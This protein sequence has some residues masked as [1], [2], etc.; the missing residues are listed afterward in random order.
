MYPIQPSPV[1]LD[2]V[3][4]NMHMA[5]P[6]LL[7]PAVEDLTSD[8]GNAGSGHAL[9]PWQTFDQNRIDVRSVYCDHVTASIHPTNDVNQKS[10]AVG[11]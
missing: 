8:D 9:Q 7:A 2:Q 5:D 4:D 6:D 3:Q 1:A 10:I 11:Q